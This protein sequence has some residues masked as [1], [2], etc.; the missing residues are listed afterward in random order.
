MGCSGG[1]RFWHTDS[2]KIEPEHSLRPDVNILLRSLENVSAEDLKVIFS[3]FLEHNLLKK[4]LPLLS[5][6]DLL[7]VGQ[8][9]ILGFE[10]LIKTYGHCEILY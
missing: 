9:L 1:L 7:E 4:T 5:C 3:P 6:G 8:W 10:P 2:T